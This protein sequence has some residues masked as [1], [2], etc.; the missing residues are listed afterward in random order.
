ML[1][2]KEQSQVNDL[3][4][5]YQVPR[6][7]VGLRRR[8][9]KASVD[10]QDYIFYQFSN[11]WSKDYGVFFIS[12]LAKDLDSSENTVRK[13]L[14]EC[15]DKKI[16][17]VHDMKIEGKLILKNTLE[18]QMLLT[19]ILEGKKSIEVDLKSSIKITDKKSILPFKKSNIFILK[20]EG[21]PFK[22][23]EVPPFKNEGV[24]LSPVEG[25]QTQSEGGKAIQSIEN[26]E[27]QDTDRKYYVIE[28][29]I[30]IEK[31]NEVKKEVS[32]PKQISDLTSKQKI[33]FTYKNLRKNDPQYLELLKQICN[34]T[35]EETLKDWLEA[36]PFIEISG[37]IPYYILNSIQNKRQLPENYLKQKSEKIKNELFKKWSDSYQKIIGRKIN[38][39][40]I[41]NNLSDLVSNIIKTFD[42]VRNYFTSKDFE[43]KCDEKN[44]RQVK[45]NQEFLK[46]I[47]KVLK[48]SELQDLVRTILSNESL[49]NRSRFLLDLKDINS[50]IS[51]ILMINDYSSKEV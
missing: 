12:S 42:F 48:V 51:S 8:M 4:S 40:M 19:E 24:P 15:F 9:S 30:Y 10:I 33:Y 37:N 21:Y 7:T 32:E 14:K 50:V 1:A 29:N 23:S 49:K 27:T 28:N 16:F 39:S 35:S 43:Y 17:L 18:N 36:R 5:Y 31:D 44:I 20:S 3:N 22:N 26:K 38:Y 46:E 45:A 34:E 13:A 11:E 2:V 6:W 41:E 25:K 47:S